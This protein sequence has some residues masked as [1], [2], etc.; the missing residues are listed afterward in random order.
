MSAFASRNIRE[1]VRDKVNLFFGL[2][3]PI[4]L[5]L[6][7]TAIQANVPVEMFEPEHVTPGLAVF[8]LSF[9]SLFSGMLI[10]KDRE[11]SLLMRLYASPMSPRDFILGYLLPLFPLALA[12]SLACYLA[13]IVLGLEISVGILVAIVVQVPAALL[14]IGIGLL[15]GSIFSDKQV[16]SLCGALLTNLSAWLSSTWFDVSLV[17]GWFEKIANALPFIHAV[18]AGRAAVSGDYAAILPELLWVGAYAVVIFVLAIVVF[19][20]KMRADI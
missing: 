17:G 2:G 8:G 18:N 4:V 12:Q 15:A 5:L 7:F 11:S 16:G 9:I 19:R 3:F 1:I 20:R 6:L 13:A 14:Y 10:A